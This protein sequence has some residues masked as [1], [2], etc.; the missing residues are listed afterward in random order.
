MLNSHVWRQWACKR[1]IPVRFGLALAIILTI[2][3]RNPC[4]GVLARD[5]PVRTPGWLANT[6]VVVVSSRGAAERVRLASGD[7]PARGDPRY[8]RHVPSVRSCHH[9]AA[10]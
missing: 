3:A 7:D 4:C 9:A 8:R 5:A 10:A 1:L 6:D 2:W